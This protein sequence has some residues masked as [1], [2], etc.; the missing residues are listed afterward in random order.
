[1]SLLTICTD[2]V[3]ETKLRLEERAGVQNGGNGEDKTVDK[4]HQG[5]GI[6]NWDKNFARGDH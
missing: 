2:I 6:R 5:L 1:M 3:K 4:N